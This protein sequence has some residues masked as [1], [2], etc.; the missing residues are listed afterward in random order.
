MSTDRRCCLVKVFD[1]DMA[2]NRAVVGD[3]DGS[4]RAQA[5]I[6]LVCLLGRRPIRRGIG[7]VQCLRLRLAVGANRAVRGESIGAVGIGGGSADD[8][9]LCIQELEVSAGDANFIRILDAVVI[10]IVVNEA[11]DRR[12]IVVAALGGNRS[13]T[14]R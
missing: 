2:A 4:K 1:T 8:R 14:A 13:G 10:G 7:E 6:E 9:A 11:A 3:V 12:A 5:R